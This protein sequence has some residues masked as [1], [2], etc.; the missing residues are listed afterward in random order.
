[1][2]AESLKKGVV[3]NS[4]ALLESPTIRAE[5]CVDANISVLEKVGQLEILPEIDGATT[6]QVAKFYGVSEDTIRNLVKRHPDE[7]KRCGYKLL[8]KNKLSKVQNEP[9][10]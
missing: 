9:H 1:M 10:T 2:Q 5:V 3:M 6:E 7:F 4:E 8:H